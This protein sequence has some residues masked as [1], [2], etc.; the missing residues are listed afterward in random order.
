LPSMAFGHVVLVGFQNT[1]NNG[2]SFPFTTSTIS[3]NQAPSSFSITTG[4]LPGINTLDFATTVFTPVCASA[5]F[6]SKPRF[7]NPRT[8]APGSQRAQFA[9]ITHQQRLDLSSFLPF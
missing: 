6:R 2:T 4:F 1:D 9:R 7:P 5:V 3:Y 8:Y